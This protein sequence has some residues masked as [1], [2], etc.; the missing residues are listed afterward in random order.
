MGLTMQLTLS[1]SNSVVRRSKTAAGRRRI[2]LTEYC[3]NELMHWRDL[4]GAGFSP[5]L[6][7][8]LRDPSRH[9]TYYQ[10]AWEAAIKAAGLSGRRVHDLRATFAS[11]ANAYQASGLTVAH[12]LGYSST[13]VLPSYVKPLD[14]N[15]K[16]V[17][18]ALD[19]ARVSRPARRVPTK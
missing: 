1:A 19:A 5:F 14:E 16:T 18:M 8:S 11:R 3:R 7:P 9:W 12:L 17:I 13:Q 2:W 10:D 6:F 4:L 15:T